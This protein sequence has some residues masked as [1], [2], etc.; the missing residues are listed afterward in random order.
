MTMGERLKGWRTKN[1]LSQR[2]AAE[3]VGTG[4]RTWADWE[5]GTT[6]EV[7]YLEALEKLTD[8]AVTIKGWAKERRA[9]RTT[10]R[11]EAVQVKAAS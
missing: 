6:P 4:Q 3:K 9:E 1:G 11:S 5:T 10:D 2:V 8:G 7:D